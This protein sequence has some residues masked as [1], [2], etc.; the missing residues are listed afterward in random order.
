MIK[1][2]EIEVQDP[3]NIIPEDSMNSW[4]RGGLPTREMVR[5]KDYLRRYQQKTF[6]SN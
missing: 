6:S 2:L 4:V 5:N 1:R 3:L